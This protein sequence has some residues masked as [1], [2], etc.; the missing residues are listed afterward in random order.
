LQSELNRYRLAAL[1]LLV[2]A[3]LT[4]MLIQRRQLSRA[5]ARLEP[6]QQQLRCV[7]VSAMA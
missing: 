5:F 1:A 7:L 2:F 4:L 6:L 3:L